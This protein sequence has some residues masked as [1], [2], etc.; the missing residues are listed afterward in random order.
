[1]RT[2]HK[3]KTVRGFYMVYNKIAKN[4]KTMYFQVAMKIFVVSSVNKTSNV[5]TYYKLLCNNN[6]KNIAIS[7][8]INSQNIN[9]IW[10]C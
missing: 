1:M 4:G 6:L 10:S 3:I 8:L 2:F 9:L 5:I 7:N